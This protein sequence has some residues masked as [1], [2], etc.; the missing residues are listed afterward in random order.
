MN[1]L[2]TKGRFN[3]IQPNIKDVENISPNCY[4]VILEPLEQGLGHTLGNALRRILLSYIPGCAITAVEIEGCQHIYSNKQGIKEDILEVLLNIKELSIKLP[5]I[6]NEARLSLNKRGIG[7]VS[8]KDI[9]LPDGV[10]ILNPNNLIC[11]LTDGNIYLNMS[12]R[13]NWG[14]GY[15]PSGTGQVD[16]EEI[17]VG[18]FLIDAYFNPIKKVK[19]SVLSTRVATRADFD[20]LILE[21]ETNGTIT[22]EESIRMAATILYEQLNS[23]IDVNY[24]Q[25]KVVEEEINPLLLRE[26][27]Y[28]ELPVRAYNCLK[29]YSIYYIG[30][31]VQK[32]ESQLL[33]T[34]NLGKKSLKDIKD[35][36]SVK[37]LSLGMKI[38]NWD[39][40]KPK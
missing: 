9:C 7:P 29:H 11:H 21:I 3:L 34:P 10:E 8:A 1:I 32:T 36:L 37:G 38:E 25:Q 22:A 17:M 26:V 30:D 27:D 15:T 19:Y 40:K 14:R 12:M 33:K 18:K 5:V 35:I 2:S 16:N 28:L 23:L 4:K 39:Q 13:V 31:L 20:S 6:Q 24:C